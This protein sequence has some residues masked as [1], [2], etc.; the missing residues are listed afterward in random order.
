MEY[1]VTAADGTQTRI[2]LLLRHASSR[3]VYICVE[4]KRP[5]PKYKNWIFFDKSSAG[6]FIEDGRMIVGEK[7]VSGVPIDYR[8]IISSRFPVSGFH[9]YN[10]YLE[11]TKEKNREKASS[12]E[13][14]EKASRQLI[15]GHTG[16]MYKLREYEKEAM[17]FFRSI[18]LI[19]TTADLFAA[20]YDIGKVSLETG[21]IDGASLKLIPQKYCAINYHPDDGLS[22]KRERSNHR[23]S[24]V[25]SD[26]E[27][28]QNRSVFVVNSSSMR[29]FLFWAG[30]YL[31]EHP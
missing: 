30:E 3:N 22:V 9:I 20:D 4:C 10:Y 13:T 27:F 28:F 25:H 31:T 8:H 29:E 2:D 7:Y 18:P 14:I 6:I 16:L 21:M 12:A 24:D 1:P 17:S 5:N 26:M 11:A 19:V 15:A 23:K